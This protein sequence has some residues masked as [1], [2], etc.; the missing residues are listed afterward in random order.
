MNVYFIQTGDVIEVG[1]TSDIDR[2]I[3][4]IQVGNPHKIQLLHS[5]STTDKTAK[6]IEVQIHQ[7][8]RKTNLNGGWFQANQYMKEFIEQIKKNG[9]ESHPEWIE[10]QYSDKYGDILQSLKR[11]LECDV[12]R[13]NTVSL[14]RLKSDLG[15]LINEIYMIPLLPKN[16]AETVRKWIDTKNEPFTVRDVYTELGIWTSNDKN[17]I[18]VIV[19]RLVKD[20]TLQKTGKYTYKK[21][22]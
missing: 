14:E 15:E 4:D 8:F 12:V 20:G 21:N 22:I 5:I 13:G 2:R 6:R 9:W 19:F 11:K 10:N 17:N 18:K 7:L 1:I 3:R 16:I